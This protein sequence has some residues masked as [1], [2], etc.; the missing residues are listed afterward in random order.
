MLLLVS[1]CLMFLL[2]GRL[3]VD[4]VDTFRRSW[5]QEGNSE[6]RNRVLGWE[7]AS[8]ALNV[9]IQV[10]FM[11]LLFVRFQVDVV[12]SCCIIYN[13]TVGHYCSL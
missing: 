10:C 1:L 13:R 9:Q 8:T 7:Q 2:F 3:G 6:G 4:V 5:E 12:V 11:F